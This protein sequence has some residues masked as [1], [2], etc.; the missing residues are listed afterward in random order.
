MD[1]KKGANA[2]NA[3]SARQKVSPDWPVSVHEP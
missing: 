2:A 1:A 3:A